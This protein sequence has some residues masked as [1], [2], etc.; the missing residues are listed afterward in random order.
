MVASS[1]AQGLTK[2]LVAVPVPP[3][4][5]PPTG[6]PPVGGQPPVVAPP[7]APPVVTQPGVQQP[8]GAEEGDLLLSKQVDGADAEDITAVM[9]EVRRV[10]ERLGGTATL[11][12]RAVRG[13]PGQ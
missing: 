8:P 2:R 7:V 11:T 3:V 1:A 6:V 4:V 13:R 12:L 10:L 9:V 5:A